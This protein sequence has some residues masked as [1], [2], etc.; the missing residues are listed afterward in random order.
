MSI[1]ERLVELLKQIDREYEQHFYSPN[2]REYF[3]DEEDFEYFAQRLLDNGVI[4]VINDDLL[5]GI[6]DYGVGVEQGEKGIYG[7]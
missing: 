6:Y 3:P 5:E 2:T 7:E 4:V 1:K